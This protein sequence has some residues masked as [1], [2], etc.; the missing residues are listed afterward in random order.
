MIV[1]SID[2]GTTNV[3]AALIDFDERD[4]KITLTRLESYRIEPV[5]EAPGAYEHDPRIVLH[6]VKNL[7]K[8][9]SRGVSIDAIVLTSYLFGLVAVDEHFDYLTNIMTWMDE[10][11]YSV[12]GD[13]RKYARELYERTGCPPLHIYALPK[14]LWLKKHSEEKFRRAKHFLDSKS[15]LMASLTGEVVTDLSS[16]SGTYQLLD[17]KKLTWDELGL[18]LAGIEE[19]QLPEVREGYSYELLR[20]GVARELGLDQKTPAIIG[21]YDGGSMIYGLSGASSGVG[22]VNLGS[23]AMIRTVSERPRIDTSPL[24]WFQTYYLMDGLWLMGG[25]INNAGIVVEYIIRLLFGIEPS[26]ANSFER[27]LG[28][29]SCATK[30]SPI[31]SI[32]FILPERF[33]FIDFKRRMGIFGLTQDAHRDDIALSVIEGV[34]LTLAYISRSMEESGA[35]Y[36]EVRVG[37]RLASHRCVRMLLA[38]ILEK[39]VVSTE[40]VDSSH[41]GN[42]LLSLRA[43]KYLGQKELTRLVNDLL[44]KAEKIYPDADRAVLYRRKFDE[45]SSILTRLYIDTEMLT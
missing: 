15:L 7:M 16:A 32:P 3:K 36:T 18:S 30:V 44:S 42:I 27:A 38:D 26:D 19:S 13:L 35:T 39:P 23:S 2:L 24:M 6:Y 5:V 11:P 29:V 45:F 20:E 25:A 22:I 12:L 40:T 34:L 28:S 1:A 33:P 43:L 31:I 10:R 8:N 41:L 9:I 21:L 14:I 17:I 4:E 37:G